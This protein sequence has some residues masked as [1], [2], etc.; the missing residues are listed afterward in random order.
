MLEI[1]EQL[2]G[3]VTV[4]APDGPI[5]KDDAQMFKQAALAAISSSMGRMAIDASNVAFLDS[6]GLEALLDLADHM[7]AVGRSL[8]MSNINETVRETM[9]V[10][11]LIDRFDI[12]EDVTPAVR[13]FL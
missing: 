8:K 7:Q 9:E 3:A 13:S 2:K 10:T 5:M 12:Y 4:L 1:R 11:G 6:Q